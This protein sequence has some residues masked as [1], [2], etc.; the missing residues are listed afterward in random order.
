MKAPIALFLAT[1]TAGCATDDPTLSNDSQE[2][3][4]NGKGS[5]FAL[6]DG[7]CAGG[8]V[9]LPR[10]GLSRE[11]A[12][13]GSNV[14]VEGIADPPSEFPPDPCYPPDPCIPPDSGKLH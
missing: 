9:S 5:I 6:Q 4:V 10:D 12:L 13:V 8:E 11:F 2:M 7:V 1:L 14:R 3:F